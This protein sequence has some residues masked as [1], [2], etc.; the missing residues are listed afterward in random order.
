[1]KRSTTLL[2]RGFKGVI[3]R[4]LNHIRLANCLNSSPWNG[5]PESV[6][7]T[8]GIPNMENMRSRRGMTGFA[9][10]EVNVSTTG[11]LL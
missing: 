7:Q 2:A 10:S 6:L 5:G 1:M 3:L 9:E 11:Y 4:C 8:D